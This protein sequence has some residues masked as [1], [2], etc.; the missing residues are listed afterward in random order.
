MEEARGGRGFVSLTSDIHKAK[1]F[2]SA[3]ALFEYWMTNSPA[4][5]VTSGG[6][7]EREKMTGVPT[8]MASAMG[9]PN[10]SYR[11]RNIIATAPLNRRTSSVPSIIP[12]QTKLGNSNAGASNSFSPH[13]RQAQEGPV[14]AAA[15]PELPEV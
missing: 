13:L 1:R 10:P 8:A 3:M 14:P 11:E 9:T 15:V 12:R 6:A 7:A 4:S 2:P 5:P